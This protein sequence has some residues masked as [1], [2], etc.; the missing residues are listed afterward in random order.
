MSANGG[1]PPPRGGPWERSEEFERGF[2]EHVI[3]RAGLR[4]PAGGHLIAL[5]RERLA[6]GAREYGPR[7]Y[8][9]DDC[10]GQMTEE[11]TDVLGWGILAALQLYLREH[12]AELGADAAGDMRAELVEIAVDGAALWRRCEAL[13]QQARRAVG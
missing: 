7:N 13:R 6:K 11:P 9:T 8:L 4:G 10:L 1:E 3:G 5:V 2:L 12:R